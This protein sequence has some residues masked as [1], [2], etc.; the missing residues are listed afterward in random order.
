[1]INSQGRKKSNFPAQKT[2]LSGASFD[3]FANG[4]NYKIS[5][6][7]LLPQLGATG[8]L[9]QVGD[10]GSVPS[11]DIQGSENRIRNVRAGSGIAAD[12]NA[13]EELEISHNFRSGN[14]TS[15]P[16][17]INSDDPVP[18]IRGIKAGPGINVSGSGDTIQISSATLPTS[19]QTVIVTSLDDL[20]KAEAGVITLEPDTQYYIYNSLDFGST[21]LVMQNSTSFEGADSSVIEVKY[22]GTGSM[23]SAVDSSIRFGRI[24]VSAPAGRF[25]SYSNP[26]SDKVIQLVDMTIASCADAASIDGCLAFSIFNSSVSFSSSGLTFAGDIGLTV[27]STHGVYISGGGSAFDF[28]GAS[29]VQTVNINNSIMILQDPTSIGVKG[30]GSSNIGTLA[31]LN[32]TRILNPGG[33]S[34]LSGIDANDTKWWFSINDS[35]EDTAP[36]GLGTL[37][38]NTTPTIIAVAGTPVLIAGSWVQE[39]G[40]LFSVSAGGRITYNGAR[41]FSGKIDA[42]LG[43]ILTNGG[44]QQVSA[45][46]YINGS[47]V[48][49]SR[50]RTSVGS[51]NSTNVGIVWNHHFNP[52]DYIEFWV[53]NDGSTAGIIV[54]DAVIRVG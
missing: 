9:V 31:A 18:T 33:G 43:V 22:T 37:N 28:S 26:A 49:N 50:A 21:R 39:D 54:Q 46:L 24:E 38:N 53:S 20:P 35:I 12:V 15:V 13:S 40:K 41:E 16:I 45:W 47:R 8:T 52:G 36:V 3:Y 19:S 14:G 25:L 30:S 5:F 44:A 51:G 17:L 7:D 11:L 23:F 6:D 10:A 27:I 42:Q 32:N 2:V 34:A 4:V 29:S 48:L 1:M